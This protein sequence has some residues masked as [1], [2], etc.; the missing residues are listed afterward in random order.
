MKRPKY[1]KVLL[2]GTIEQLNEYIGQSGKCLVVDWRG[3]EQDLID[4]LAELLPKAGLAWEWVDEEDD[5]YVTYRSLR[6]KI[7]LTLSP[8]DRCITLRRLNEILAGDYEVQVFRH[9]LGDDTHCFYAKRCEWWSA[10]QRLFPAEIERVFA[11][12][13]PEMDFPYMAPAEGLQP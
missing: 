6:H 10:M 11:R 5:I 9:T 4:N 1:D 7:G 8:R 12:I 13:T 3:Y 2:N